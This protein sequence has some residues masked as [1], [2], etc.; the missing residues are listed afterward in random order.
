MKKIH[1]Y[2]DSMHRT[3]PSNIMYCGL[4]MRAIVANGEYFRFKDMSEEVTCKTCISS[5][6]ARGGNIAEALKNRKRI[7]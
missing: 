1:L 5:Y 3:I 2:K 4:I 7:G 6:I